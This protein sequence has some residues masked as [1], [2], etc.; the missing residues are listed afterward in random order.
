MRSRVLRFLYLR[1]YRISLI[2]LDLIFFVL[3]VYLTFLFSN[4][5]QPGVYFYVVGIGV[6]FV[7]AVSFLLYSVSRYAVRQIF[8]AVLVT[9]VLLNL[10]VLYSDALKVSRLALGLTLPFLEM[11]ILGYRLILRRIRKKKETKGKN[12]VKKVVILG[13][14]R[15]AQDITEEIKINQSEQ[16][17][18]VGFIDPE[19]EK[20]EIK[21][22]K[23]KIL[24]S[25]SSL[26]KII[27][28]KDIDEVIVAFPAYTPEVHRRIEK[29]MVEHSELEVSFK[30]S[31]CLHENLVGRLKVNHIPEL[32]LLDLAPV[33]HQ[34][35]YLIYKRTL[36][37]CGSFFGLLFLFPLLL[38]IA[39]LLKCCHKG[40]VLYKQKRLGES[41]R[42]FWLYKFRS[43]V[44]GAEK[45][46][47]PVWASK[48]DQRVT[49][50]GRFLRKW[51]LDELPQLWNVLKG[52]ISLVGPRPER[53]YF[54]EKH[55]ELRGKRLNVKPGVTGLAQVNGRYELTA[56]HKAK[57]DYLYLKHCSLGLDMKILL[58]TVW[59][60]LS[61]KGVK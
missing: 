7:V 3:A 17:K 58:Q 37:I 59:V 12:R 52:D 50:L 38:I 15:E 20:S 49:K 56:R 5:D 19:I 57:Y 46:T 35:R 45:D 54:V 14:G 11:F 47:G 4:R 42:P 41:G 36:D 27:R 23:E 1:K 55:K 18:L 32:F 10:A 26:Y 24:G 34:K 29:I 48:D 9:W 39:L 28:D 22:D 25:I 2:V 13:V 43:M 6:W 21:V 44:S 61:R 8:S 51:S 16:Y 33:S 40:S 31:P 53:P 60:V 30:I